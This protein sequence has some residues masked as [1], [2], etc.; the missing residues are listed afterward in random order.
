MIDTSTAK[1]WTTILVSW[2]SLLGL[3]VGGVWSVLEYIG[4]QEQNEVEAVLERLKQLDDG[5]VANAYFEVEDAWIKGVGKLNGEL[6]KRRD[7]EDLSEFYRG[8][9]L[10]FVEENRLASELRRT[11]QFFER[12]AA[13]VD[14]GICDRETA[15]RLVGPQALRIRNNYYPY[16]ERLRTVTK[17]DN[18]LAQ[19]NEF[20]RQ[21]YMWKN[22]ADS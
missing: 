15:Y 11:M 22:G 17:N 21:Y 9:V 10:R 14:A 1:D 3:L 5:A 2:I 18:Y 8:Y 16:I 12:V 4:R 13:C 19:F 20:A 7:N 6:D